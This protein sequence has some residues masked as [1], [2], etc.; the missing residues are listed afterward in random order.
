MISEA[1]S[2]LEGTRLQ[3]RGR[4][5]D[6]FEGCFYLM[7]FHSSV[8]SLLIEGSIIM[9]WGLTLRGWS[10]MEGDNLTWPRPLLDKLLVS[11]AFPAPSGPPPAPLRHSAHSHSSFPF[12]SLTFTF[13][14]LCRT[15]WWH[16]LRSNEEGART[17]TG[18]WAGI[19]RDFVSSRQK[20]GE[21]GGIDEDRPAKL[22]AGYMASILSYPS[23]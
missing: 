19:S 20:G 16:D 13:G 6:S 5:R 22:R 14:H 8:G 3:V 12:V 1:L 18:L 15:Q 21:A 9:K 4:S 10:M 23:S 7:R 11:S 17:I 2:Y